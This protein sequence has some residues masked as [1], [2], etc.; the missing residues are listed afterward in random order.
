[1]YFVYND[2]FKKKKLIISETEA[3][4]FAFGSL[5]RVRKIYIYISHLELY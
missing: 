1:M 5:L 3:P 4:L 2:L